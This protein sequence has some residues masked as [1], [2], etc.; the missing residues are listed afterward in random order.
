MNPNNLFMEVTVES[1]Q[2][3][4]VLGM[5]LPKGERQTF[6][7]LNF[8][9]GSTRVSSKNKITEIANKALRQ[10]WDNAYTFNDLIKSLGGE[11]V[12]AR[13]NADYDFSLDTLEKD[14]FIKVFTEIEVEA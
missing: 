5:F 2:K 4:N 3:Q 10:Q 6:V 13:E 12:D 1:I 11:L 14:S 8:G 9:A 7:L